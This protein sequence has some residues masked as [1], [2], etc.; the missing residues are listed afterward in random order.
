MIF[1]PFESLTGDVEAAFERVKSR[2]SGKDSAQATHSAGGGMIQAMLSRGMIK[3]CA[4]ALIDAIPNS[5]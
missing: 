4:V 2:S 3:G 5:G 1:T